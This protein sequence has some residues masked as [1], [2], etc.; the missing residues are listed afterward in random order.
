[1]DTWP[2]VAEERLVLAEVLAGLTPQ[3]WETPSLCGA[4]TARAVATHLLLLR[5]QGGQA[6]VH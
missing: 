6:A 5:G 4:W 3:Q 1:M 2:A